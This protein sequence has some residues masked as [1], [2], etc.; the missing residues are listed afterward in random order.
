MTPPPFH[1]GNLRAELLD[2]AE[3]MLR[4][5]GVDAVSLRDLARR[6]GV[7]HGAPRSHFI[8]R[9]ALLDALAE[10]GF[11]RMTE[12]VTTAGAA[13]GT[14]RDRL[15]S[16]A[17]A[18][19]RF[20]VADAALMEL[21]FSAKGERRAEPVEAAAGRMFSAFDDLFDADFREGRCTGADA[22]RTKLLLVAALQGTAALLTSHRIT[23][24]QGDDLIDDT[25]DLLLEHAF[26][27]PSAAVE[28]RVDPPRR[29]GTT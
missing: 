17:T 3:Q 6:A 29:S 10:R 8:D 15:H 14:V 28:D 16:V 4:E 23:R 25:V 18:Y 7:S 12:E 22:T 1:H 24:Q 13:P 5:Q 2:R 20:A 11:A 21:M 26:P 19:V 9:Q 27:R